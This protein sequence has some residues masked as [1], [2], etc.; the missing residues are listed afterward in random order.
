MVEEEQMKRRRDRKA[1]KALAARFQ[2]GRSRSDEWDETPVSAEVL[3]QRAVVTSVR[4]PVAEFAALQKAAVALGQTVSEFVRA[5]V[6]TRLRGAAR[7][8]AIHI[9]SSADRE[10][11][12][13]VTFVSSHPEAGQTRN[14]S[15]AEVKYANLGRR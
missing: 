2:A 9:A 6:A 7:V 8:Q 12:S 3:P 11:P 1:D 4:F 5:A 14:P 10:A 13:Q 15:P